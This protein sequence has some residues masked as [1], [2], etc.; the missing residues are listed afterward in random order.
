MIYISYI[1][2]IIIIMPY[3]NPMNQPG[4]NGMPESFE[5]CSV[6]GSLVNLATVAADVG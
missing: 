6:R 1:Y 4:F 5:H 2:T 3:G